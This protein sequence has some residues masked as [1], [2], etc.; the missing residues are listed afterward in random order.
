M[1]RKKKT[2]D[3][4]SET[5]AGLEAVVVAEQVALA[6]ERTVADPYVKNARD[7]LQSIGTKEQQVLCTAHVVSHRGLFLELSSLTK[8]IGQVLKGMKSPPAPVR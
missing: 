4:A 6:K 1:E 5:A 3:E 7:A 2:F 8:C